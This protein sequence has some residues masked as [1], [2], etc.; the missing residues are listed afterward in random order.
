MARLLAAAA[1]L[2]VAAVFGLGEASAQAV[3]NVPGPPVVAAVDANGVDLIGGSYDYAYARLSIGGEGSGLARSQM[4]A[5]VDDFSGSIVRLPYNGNSL[6]TFYFTVRLGKSAENFSKITGA[7]AY[8]PW[9]RNGSSFNCTAANCFYTLADGTVA[10]FVLTSDVTTP[11]YYNADATVGYLTSLT[12]PN[13]EVITLTYPIGSPI[14]AGNPLTVSSSL[15]WMFKYQR[16]TRIQPPSRVDAI[17]T[18]ID[19]CSPTATSCTGTT[20]AWPYVADKTNAL[21][22]TTGLSILYSNSPCPCNTGTPE[23]NAFYPL[24]LPALITTAN[25]VS[26]SIDY[27]PDL[28]VIYTGDD[29]RMPEGGDPHWVST[30]KI[31]SSIWRYNFERDNPN[32]PTLRTNIVTDP[33]GGVRTVLVNIQTS[34][35]L[36]DTDPLGRKTSYTYTA[37]KVKRVIPPDASFGSDGVVNGGYKEYAYDARGNVTEVR[38][39]AKAASGLADSVVSAGYDA[40][41]VNP[42]TCNKANWVKDARGNQTDYTYSPDHGGVLT[43]TG[44]ADANGVRP[45][46]RYTYAQL[47]PKVKDASGALINST[48]VWRL[49]Q[50]ETCSASTD[51]CAGSANQSM[52]LYEY[53]QNNLLLT[54]TT[55]K[56][57]DGSVSQTT[58]YGYDSIGNIIWIDGPLPGTGDTSRTYYDALRRVTGKVG[59]DPDGAGPLLHPANRITYD[60][61]DQVVL[62]ETGTATNQSDTGMASFV[63]SQQL[64]TEYDAL[65]RKAKETLSVGGAAQALTQYGYDAMGRPQCTAVRMNPAAFSSAPDACTLGVEG[66]FGPDRIGKV[67]YDAANQVLQLRKAVGTPVEQAEVTYSYTSSGKQEYVVDANGNRTKWDYDGFDRLARWTFP[68]TTRPAAFDPSTQASALASAGGLNA[69]D[70]EIYGYDAVGNRTSLRKRDGQTIGYVYDALN[71]MTLKDLPSG[72]DVYYDYDL[73]GLQLYARFG[74][75]A[76][77]GLT[78]TYD[79]LGRVKSASNTL[80]GAART[81]S[82]TYNA[83]GARTELKFP[84]NVIF[85]YEYDDLGRMTA[86][87]EGG[88]T[89]IVGLSYDNLGRRTALSQG[90]ATSYGYDAVGRLT[91]LSH[92]LSGSLGDVAFGVVKYSPANQVMEVTT[93]NSIY[94]WRPTS[95]SAS[96]AYAAN[97]LNQYATVGGSSLAYDLNG[98]LTFDGATTYGYDVENRLTSASGPASASLAYDP[99]GRLWKTTAAQTTQFLNDGP[100]LVAEYDGS[101]NL[102]RRYVHGPGVDEPLVWYEGS[103]LSNRR[104]LR[105]DRQGSIVAITDGNGVSLAIDTYD[106]YGVPA[107]SN[108]GRFQYTGQAWLPEL[109]LYHYK[110]RIYSP[111]LGRFLQTDPIGYDDD[112]NLYAYTGDDPVNKADP[113]GLATGVSETAAGIALAGIVLYV[114]TDCALKQCFSQA[115]DGASDAI[116]KFLRGPGPYIPPSVR[117]ELSRVGS[118]MPDPDGDWNVRDQQN[119]LSGKARDARWAE[120][121]GNGSGL[122]SHANAHRAEVGARNAREYDLSA[123]QTI[124]SGRSFTY[125]DRATNELRR[126]Y[127]DNRGRFTATSEQGG[128]V[129]IRTHFRPE[130]PLDYVKGLPGSTW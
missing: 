127:L 116:G 77:L 5:G 62:L 35:I 123:R 72:D 105:G 52:T 60:A 2:S 47:Y 85:T 102:L 126:G 67:I 95:S 49:T 17:N 18:S 53:N 6:S 75:S 111:T 8:S 39:V 74:S 81:L 58:T 37:D 43:I 26:R 82:Y 130:K 14:Y 104:L 25:G 117:P 44:P 27:A 86:I 1:T 115:A 90:V 100:A 11:Y 118:P 20:V 12:K 10:N 22:H 114:T 9:R 31:G 124:Q 32:I 50:M 28:Y 83:A 78:S 56:A 107:A 54:A 23:P 63:A 4:P 103:G 88:T 42:K 13:G 110:A 61:D 66:V 108:Q 87:K 59:P 91:S 55:K 46:T 80:S 71:R 128:R 45:Q 121:D 92:D 21:G 29:G 79:A 113:T 33:L 109:G 3:I 40:T 76:G 101:G 96:R 19:Y 93:S 65:G 57:G 30:I 120:S 41:C 64:V 99:M 16:P 73:Q 112:F 129:T 122:R 69:A 70:Y 68:S 24:A 48:P 89:T 94:V 36:S 106:E 125:R 98:N 34:Q 119:Q 15:G 7:G 97:G 38:Q 84:D 51:G